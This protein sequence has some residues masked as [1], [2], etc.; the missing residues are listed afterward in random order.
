MAQFENKVVIVTGGATGI[1]RAAAIAFAR[2]AAAVT[3]ADINEEA[4]Q[5]A[6]NAIQASGGQALFV[7]ADVAL[8]SGAREAVART[9]AAFGGVDVLFNNVGI[10]PETSYRNVE[11]LAEEVWDRVMAVNVKSR[12]LMAKYAVPEMRKRGGGVII[13]NASVQGLKSQKLVPVY[14]ASKGADLSLTQNM[15]LDYAEE[16]IRVLAVCPGSID[17][18]ILRQAAAV[19]SPGD[20][21]GQIRRWGKNHPIGRVGKPEEVAEVVLFLAGSRASFMTG[22]YVC[23]DGGLMARGPWASGSES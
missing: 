13:H 20:V 11:D 5:S 3:I 21:D 10:Q 8:A 23:V 22:E 2:E 16:N 14:A 12:F 7:K 19:A 1:G 9:V 18:P 4:G 6:A 15:A 17:T